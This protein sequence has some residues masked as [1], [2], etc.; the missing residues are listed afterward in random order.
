MWTFAAL[1]VMCTTDNTHRVPGVGLIES[2]RLSYYVLTFNF[3][4]FSRV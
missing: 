3:K 4:H 2:L 1:Q